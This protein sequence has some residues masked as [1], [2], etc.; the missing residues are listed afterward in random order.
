[1]NRRKISYKF[2]ENYGTAWKN[3]LSSRWIWIPSTNEKESTNEEGKKV[4]IFELSPKENWIRKKNE[5]MMKDKQLMFGLI[6]FINIIILPFLWRA[7]WKRRKCYRVWDEKN[8]ARKF[9]KRKGI[10]KNCAKI[11]ACFG[12]IWKWKNFLCGLGN[13][14]LRF[15]LILHEI[16]LIIKEI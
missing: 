9:L 16:Y 4:K 12:R 13:F 1:M 3:F 7:E 14:F 5:W 6:V 2:N 10:K 15:I 8:T 11:D